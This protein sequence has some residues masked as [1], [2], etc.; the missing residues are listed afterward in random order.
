MDIFMIQM[1]TYVIAFTAM[2]ATPCYFLLV[3][4]SLPKYYLG[5]AVIPFLGVILLLWV[6]A[7]LPWPNSGTTETRT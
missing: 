2:L 3:R 6:I 4:A 7:I 5:L 1:V